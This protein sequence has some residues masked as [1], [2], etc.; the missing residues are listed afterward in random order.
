MGSRM[1]GH[2]ERDTA[3]QEARSRKSGMRRRRT[4]MR[5]CEGQDVEGAEWPDAH[6]GPRRRRK[7]KRLVMNNEKKKTTYKVVNTC[8]G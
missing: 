2:N 7:G 1:R 5:G 8:K 4:G 3:T 6:T